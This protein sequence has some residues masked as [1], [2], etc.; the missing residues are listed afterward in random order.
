[1]VR[2]VDGPNELSGRVEVFIRGSWGTVC[3]DEFTDLEASVICRQLGYSGGEARYS[4]FYGAGHGDIKWTN[5]KCHPD[6][7]NLFKCDRKMKV[8]GFCDH[9]EDVGV[10]CQKG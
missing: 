3:D 5:M 2:L 8:E 7:E 10:V 4:A 9:T 6:V 1:M